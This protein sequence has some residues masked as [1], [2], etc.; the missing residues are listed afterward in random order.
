MI[1]ARVLITNIY[2]VSHTE[3]LLVLLDLYDFFHVGGL[4]AQITA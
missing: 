2:A 4:G 1:D 3:S